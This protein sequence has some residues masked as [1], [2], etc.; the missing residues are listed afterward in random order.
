M[1][2]INIVC[3]CESNIIKIPYKCNG[4]NVQQGENGAAFRN[5]IVRTIKLSPKFHRATHF[6]ALKRTSPVLNDQTS[7]AVEVAEKIGVL[8]Y[9]K[10][11]YI[12]AHG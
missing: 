1:I 7:T 2:L 12:V 11:K 8:N 9:I 3:V 5:K 6:F 10:A 4:N